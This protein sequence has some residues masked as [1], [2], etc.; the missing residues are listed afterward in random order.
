MLKKI[1][2]LD[3]FDLNWDISSKD[4]NQVE[5]TSSGKY[6]L[7]EGIV[8]Y[9]YHMI[10]SIFYFKFNIHPFDRKVV[11]FSGTKN[12]CLTV[13][14]LKFDCE[15]RHVKFG[16][17]TSYKGNNS[18]EALPYIIS[19]FFL[20]FYI[21][22]Y[23]KEKCKF[24]RRIMRCRFDRFMFS[25]GLYFFYQLTLC[26]GKVDLVIFSNDHSVWQR[27]L[28][29]AC[30]EKKIKTAYVQH[31]NVSEFFPPLGFDFA[32]LDG[33]YAKS[34]YKGNDCKVFLVGCLRFQDFYKNRKLDV[35]TTLLCFNKID[36]LFSIKKIIDYFD[37]NELPFNIRLHPGEQR[38]NVIN[39]ISEKYSKKDVSKLDLYETLSKHRYCLSGTS[40]IFL[41]ASILGLY[42]MSIRDIFYDYYHFERNGLVKVFEKIDD[43]NFDEIRTTNLEA[44]SLYNFVDD[45]LTVFRNPSDRIRSILVY[46]GLI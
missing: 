9:F 18:F 46:E 41:E 29:K 37:K 16:N 13:E 2:E 33:K 43:I 19:I 15:F 5:I 1:Y 34:C 39:F 4:I 36:S 21:K 28:L 8:R 20:P 14:K 7:F 32:F 44:L 17:Q 27:A 3:I 26:E 25:Y 38:K 30:L 24:K 42:S 35:D 10:K 40:S 31:A 23:Y 45:E 11:L 6:D 22:S 12:Q